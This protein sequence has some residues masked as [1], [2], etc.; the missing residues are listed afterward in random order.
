MLLHVRRKPLVQDVH[1]FPFRGPIERERCPYA[2]SDNKQGGSD[3]RLKVM[4]LEL[5]SEM[6]ER[7]H[8]V[9]SRLL[10]LVPPQELV[11]FEDI[12]VLFSRLIPSPVKAED[13]STTRFCGWDGR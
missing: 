1:D 12:G 13:Q 8:L 4:M 3:A 5:L 6:N 2:T 10:I 11:K 7:A 9:I